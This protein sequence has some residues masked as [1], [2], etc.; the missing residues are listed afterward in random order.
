M[1][2]CPDGNDF[3]VNIPTDY[4]TIHPQIKVWK[5]QKAL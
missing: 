5:L 2:T 4:F 1:R 3:V